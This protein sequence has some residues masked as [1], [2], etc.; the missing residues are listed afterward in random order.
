MSCADNYMN[1]YN[2][3]NESETILNI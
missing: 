3:A 2:N 1:K